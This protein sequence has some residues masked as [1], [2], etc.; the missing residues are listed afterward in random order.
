MAKAP[1][2]KTPKAPKKPPPAKGSVPGD[3]GADGISDVKMG[4][5]FVR[6]LHK[7]EVI[8]AKME[9]LKADARNQ[10]KAMKI[11]GFETYEINYAIKLRKHDNDEMLEQRRREARVARWL[12]HPIGTQSDFLADLTHNKANGRDPEALGRVAGAEGATYKP[13]ANLNQD[14]AQRWITGWHAGQEK[15]AGA[16]IKAPTEQPDF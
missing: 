6:E 15:M 12:A 8:L 3:N 14:D 2:D 4:D 11:D 1:K 9:T 13:P 16:G 7:L 5:H 10:R